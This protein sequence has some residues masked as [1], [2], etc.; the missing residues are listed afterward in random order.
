MS[1]HQRVGHHAASSSVAA[2]FDQAAVR[3]SERM[4]AAEARHA[5]L[6]AALK[7]ARIDA[8]ATAQ[9][10]GAPMAVVETKK[11]HHHKTVHEAK[12]CNS[13][14]GTFDP[15]PGSLALTGQLHGCPRIYTGGEGKISVS[16]AE[17]K[18]RR[19]SIRA[20][21]ADTDAQHWTIESFLAACYTPSETAATDRGAGHLLAHLCHDRTPT[22]DL[23]LET[24][25]GQVWL[26]ARVACFPG[27]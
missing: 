25:S 3:L 6:R 10:L 15:T 24:P 22:G 12:Q 11:K 18:P 4:A 5:A 9:T 26:G 19:V 2:P 8:R 20:T 7:E 16:G 27:M 13:I 1:H 14:T 23:A 21:T 17:E